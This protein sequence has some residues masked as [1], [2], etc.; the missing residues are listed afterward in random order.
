MKKQLGI[1]FACLFVVMIGYGLTLP[2]LTFYIERLALAEGSTSQKASVHVGTLTGVFALM[3]FFFAPLWGKWSDR[4]GRRPLFLIG[5]SGYAVTNVLFGLGTNLFVLYTAR[6]LG[7]VLSAAV[8]P[9]ASAYVSDVTF[10]KE[11]GKGMAWLASAVSLGLVVGPAMGAWLSRLNWSFT[12]RSGGFY[13]DDF[14]IPFFAAALLGVVALFSAVVWLDESFSLPGSAPNRKWE[15]TGDTLKSVPRWSRISESFARLLSMSFLGQF[16]LTLFEG[17]FALHGQ[18]VLG[19]GPAQMGLVFM[20]CGL[21]M[22]AAQVSVVGWLIGRIGEKP[23]LS[24]GFGL[25]GVGLVLLMTAQTLGLI[26]VYVAIFAFGMAALSPSLAALVSKQA[27]RHSGRA[28]GMQ[29]A[30]NSLG[31]AGGPLVGGLLL[32]WY[33]HVPYLLTALPLIGTAVFIGRKTWSRKGLL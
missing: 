4:V 23:L 32:A 9:A 21:A 13:A 31:Q 10:E 17:T 19:F 16:A 20:I 3:Q 2:V 26:L 12:W 15:E 6:I 25:M 18:R 8:L 14:S 27:G 33:V 22:A 24:V 11:R 28:L 1:L 7:G 5:L 30:V 29:S